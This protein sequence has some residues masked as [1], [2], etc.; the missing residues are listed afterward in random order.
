MSNKV[1]SLNGEDWKIVFDTIAE[2]IE[3]AI[4]ENIIVETGNI[5]PLTIYSGTQLYHQTEDFIET[6]SMLEN[7]KDAASEACGEIAD[8]YLDFVTE[9]QHEDL[10]KLIV[11]WV[12][13]NNLQPD[14]YNIINIESLHIDNIQDYL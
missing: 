11:Q 6:H 5:Q 2:A 8:D 12:K 9:K 10:K 7:I 4:N 13:S 14:W 1:Y 3:Y